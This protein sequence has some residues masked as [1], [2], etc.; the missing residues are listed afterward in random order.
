MPRLGPIRRGD[1]VHY[2][3]IAGFTGPYIGGKHQ[4]MIKSVIRLR[5]PSPH[6]VT[7]AW[8]C[9]FGFFVRQASTGKRGRSCR[10]HRWRTK[11]LRFWQGDEW[12][13]TRDVALFLDRAF[14][15]PQG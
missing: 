8:T 14:P 10:T 6:Q 9:L 12:E 15:L 3:R 13:T 1:L 11:R 7:S 2:L 4:F 5:I